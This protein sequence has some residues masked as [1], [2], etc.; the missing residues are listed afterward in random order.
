MLRRNH[1]NPGNGKVRF[2]VIGATSFVAQAAVIPAIIESHK[3]ELVG[4][5][6]QSNKTK[7]TGK[8]GVTIFNSYADLIRSETVDA[9]YIPLPNA[10]HA[11]AVRFAI[12]QHKQVLCEKPLAM[13]E[14]EGRDLVNLA[15]RNEVVLMEA[16]MTRHHPR[17]RELQTI[18][19]KRDTVRIRH[20]H[21]RFTGTLARPD[22]YRWNPKMGGGSLR[23]VGIYL[24]API[25]E[26]MEQQPV[27]VWGRASWA[28][29]GVDES[30]S[31]LLSFED[32]VTAS[33]YSS[34]VA[35]EDQTLEFVLQ[36]GKIHV[37]KAFTPTTTD[38]T[39]DVSDHSGVR[40]TFKTKGANSYL[41]MINHF[42]D[43]AHG[44]AQPARPQSESLLVQKIIDRLLL[45]ATHERV[46]FLS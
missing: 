15:Q 41:E 34:F 1:D 11:D 19:S 8:H 2:G 42:C 21:A 37:D 6:S 35:G 26:A 14:Q 4:L 46:E 44:I 18:I 40:Q 10:L 36:K 16:Y 28:P 5:A 27:S 45:S 30:F 39:F 7:L 33:I 43:L 29:T 23:D 20:I 12:S 3:A 24:L 31:G 13:S 32:G 9:V 17:S 22:D 38:N 25:V